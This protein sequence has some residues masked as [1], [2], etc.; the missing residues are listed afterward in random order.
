MKFIVL[1]KLCFFHFLYCFHGKKWLIVLLAA[2]DSRGRGKMKLL[3]F[4]ISKKSCSVSPQ[5]WKITIKTN[6]DIALRLYELLTMNLS[7]PFIIDNLPIDNH[8]LTIFPHLFYVLNCMRDH[9]NGG[10]Y[11]LLMKCLCICHP[12]IQSP[13]RQNY[14]KILLVRASW[15]YHYFCGGGLWSS[16]FIIY[17]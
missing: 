16:R 2:W 4:Q 15:N 9:P 17:F 12:P 10:S 13:L 6:L 5:N 8:Y 1:Q 11:Q 7:S 3:I 14:T